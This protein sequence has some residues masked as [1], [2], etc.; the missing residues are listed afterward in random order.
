MTSKSQTL[1][2]ENNEASIDLR[3]N[4]SLGIDIRT[5]AIVPPFN[6]DGRGGNPP[7]VYKSIGT[8]AYVTPTKKTAGLRV[9]AL[10][11]LGK[12]HEIKKLTDGKLQCG[13]WIIQSELSAEKT[14]QLTVNSSDQSCL[15]ILKTPQE[16]KARL[17]Q[18]INGKVKVLETGDVLPLA[19]RRLPEE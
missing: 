6:V 9:L 17:T 7:P 5:E 19:A 13:K 15:F 1:T 18:I 14:A 2:V 4:I 12:K 16:G 3:A 8:H 11:Q 10:I